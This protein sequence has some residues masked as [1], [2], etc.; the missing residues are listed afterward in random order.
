M[1]SLIWENKLIKKEFAFPIKYTFKKFI[2]RKLNYDI[3]TEED[4]Y[5]IKKLIKNYSITYK[6]SFLNEKTL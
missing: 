1:T 2:N 3:D 4:I 6:D 5:K